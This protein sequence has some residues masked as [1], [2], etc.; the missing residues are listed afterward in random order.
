MLIILSTHPVQY[1]V[2]LWQ[3]LQRDNRVPFQVWYLTDHGTR[4][5][6]D[7]DF[8]KTF[9]W[10]IDTLSGYSYR[11]LNVPQDATPSSFTRCRLTQSLAGPLSNAGAKAVWVLGWQVSAYWQA[12]RQTRRGYRS[13]AARR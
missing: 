11:F 7:R 1:H 12:I 13:M 6:L 5:T 3:A 2:P 8:G 4:P 9:A 10:D